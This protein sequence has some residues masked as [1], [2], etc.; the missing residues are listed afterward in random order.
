MAT[1]QDFDAS[2]NLLQA[3]LWQYEDAE[4]LLSLARAK[5]DW[6]N[7]HQSEFWENWYR[8]VFNIDTANDFGLSV[9]GRILNIRLNTEDGRPLTGDIFGFGDFYANYDNGY[10]HDG[11]LERGSLSTAQKRLVIRLRYFQLT[12]RATIPEINK[13]M[14]KLFEESGRVLVWDNMD[15]SI[16]YYFQFA[17]SQPLRYILD[18]YDLLPRP[19]AVDVEWRIL[20]RP[21]FGYD[22]PSFKNYDNG[23]YGA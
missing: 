9:W 6:V 7:Q 1:I 13:F 11:V 4:K 12:T 16:V 18:Q 3:I 14:A 2:V 5:Q 15:M 8:D 20:P 22:N 17:P 21:R 19:A 10:Y 23:T